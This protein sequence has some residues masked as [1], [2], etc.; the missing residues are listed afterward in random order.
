MNLYVKGAN[1]Q[2]VALALVQEG[3][4]ANGPRRLPPG[5]TASGVV[6]TCEISALDTYERNTVFRCRHEPMQL[7]TAATIFSAPW[8]VIC[9]LLLAVAPAVAKEVSC[10]FA[11]PTAALV[12]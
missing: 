10:H 8:I 2:G 1:G 12:S 6:V 3:A 5:G 4:S 7:K 11:T 9:I